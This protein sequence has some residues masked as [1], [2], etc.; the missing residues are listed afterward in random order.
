MDQAASLFNQFMGKIKTKAEMPQ[1]LKVNNTPIKNPQEICHEMNKYFV[2]I[3]E[4]L[5]ATATIITNKLHHK[6]F[7]GKRQTSSIVLHP[8]PEYDLLE[9]I[10]RINSHKSS[11]YIDIPTTLLKEF[12]F[13]ISR[14]NNCLEAVYPDILKILKVVCLHKRGSKCEMG[15]YTDLFRFSHQSTKFLKLFCKS[16][17]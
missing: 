5:S 11:G 7:L 10:A 1:K 15:I 12:K 9:I 2:A 14:F 4:K 13:I 3:G 6:R 17:L 8:P 16:D